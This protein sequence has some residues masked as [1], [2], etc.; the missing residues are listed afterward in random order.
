MVL[1]SLQLRIVA[2]A[3]SVVDRVGIDAVGLQRLGRLRVG[4]LRGPCRNGLV[5]LRRTL[6]AR[7]LIPAC[8]PI[9]DEPDG[10]SQRCPPVIGAG[11]SHPLVVARARIH[12]VGAH[13]R[14]LVAAPLRIPAVDRRIQYRRRQV[15]QGCFG[16]RHIDVAAGSGA[17]A[18]LQRRHQRRHDDA[19]RQEVGVGAI[20]AG[21][22]PVRPSSDLVEAGDRS[23]HEPVAGKARVR[24][25][26]AQQ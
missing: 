5:D 17:V 12:A 24:P 20:R 9:A 15:V 8:C 3:L 23:C 2:A 6:P 18:P 10:V 16:L 22:S 19:W 14:I 25:A 7:S 13:V 26:L 11:N 1:P 21:R 4:A